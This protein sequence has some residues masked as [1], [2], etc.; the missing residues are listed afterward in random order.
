MTIRASI[1]GPQETMDR[2]AATPPMLEPAKADAD[3]D[4]RRGQFRS[5]SG[6]QTSCGMATINCRGGGSQ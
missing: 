3:Q 4:S 2:L 6:S 1:Y 5:K